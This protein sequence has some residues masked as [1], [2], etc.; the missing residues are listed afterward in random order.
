MQA[1]FSTGLTKTLQLHINPVLFNFQDASHMAKDMNIHYPKKIV[2][3]ISISGQSLEKALHP[4]P[5]NAPD[6]HLELSTKLW[7]LR[8]NWHFNLHEL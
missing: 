2:I 5:V 3:F 7:G 8:L 1:V 6:S 4:R